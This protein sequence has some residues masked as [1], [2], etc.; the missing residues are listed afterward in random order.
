MLEPDWV[1]FNGKIV[2]D[3]YDFATP[4]TKLA[5]G[6]LISTENLTL[7]AKYGSLASSN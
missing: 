3:G 5:S 1:G 7:I 4:P 6:S 2:C